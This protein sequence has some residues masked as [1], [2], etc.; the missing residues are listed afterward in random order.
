[1]SKIPQK[2]HDSY[3]SPS[4]IKHFRTKLIIYNWKLLLKLEKLLSNSFSAM[5]QENFRRGSGKV[6]VSCVVHVLLEFVFTV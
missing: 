2:F 3:A 1:M 6:F 5:L 4:F